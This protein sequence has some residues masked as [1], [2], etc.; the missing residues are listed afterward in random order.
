MFCDSDDYVL[1]LVSGDI[2]DIGRILRVNK[3]VDNLLGY[4]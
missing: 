4:S 1:L 3:G 2:K